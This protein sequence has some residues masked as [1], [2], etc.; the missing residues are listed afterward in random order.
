M[1]ITKEIKHTASDTS[2]TVLIFYVDVIEIDTLTSLVHEPINMFF[3][4]GV[5]QLELLLHLCNN[6]M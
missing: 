5:K 4:C 1:F 6:S 3:E 2:I